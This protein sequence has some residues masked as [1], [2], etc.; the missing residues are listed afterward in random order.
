MSSASQFQDTTAED[1]RTIKWGGWSIVGVVFFAW[2][3]WLSLLAIGT[4]ASVVQQEER[5][6][7]HFEQLRQDIRDVKDE[8][9]ALRKSAGAPL[10]VSK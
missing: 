9:V 5:E 7:N 8:V 3:G 2:A 6:T 4:Q 10:S 1:L